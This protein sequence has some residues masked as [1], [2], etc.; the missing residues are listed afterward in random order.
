MLG[1]LE[2]GCV[3]VSCLEFFIIIFS[4]FGFLASLFQ[5]RCP[6]C[7]DMMVPPIQ[8]GHIFFFFSQVPWFPVQLVQQ[9]CFSLWVDMMV[10]PIR[11]G[12]CSGPLVIPASFFF[13]IFLLMLLLTIGTIVFRERRTVRV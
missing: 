1:R 6:R 10:P 2:L 4:L 3:F 9:R 12:L 7:V 13:V 8:A 11:A 5:Q